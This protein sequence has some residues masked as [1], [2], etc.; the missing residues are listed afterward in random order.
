MPALGL[1]PRVDP[2]TQRKIAR[3]GKTA[4]LPD[5]VRQRRGK[6]PDLKS[7]HS[8]SQVIKSIAASR[9]GEEPI[10]TGRRQSE[11]VAFTCDVTVSGPLSPE[12]AR[13]ETIG[14]V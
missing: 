6:R 1:D 10:S 8:T 7:E 13:S 12:E 4:G 14:D 2:G 9:F 5:Q 3:A 11:E